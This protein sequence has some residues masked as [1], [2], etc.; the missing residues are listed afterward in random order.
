MH[1]N[2]F[3]FPIGGSWY[4]LISCKLTISDSNVGINLLPFPLY[5]TTKIR[6]QNVETAQTLPTTNVDMFIPHT[7]I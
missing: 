4:F 6:D 5:L 3:L 2:K 7:T 1:I